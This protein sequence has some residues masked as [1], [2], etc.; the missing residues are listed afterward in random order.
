MEVSSLLLTLIIVSYDLKSIGLTDVP[1]ICTSKVDTGVIHQARK[2]KDLC[3]EYLNAEIQMGHHSSII[4][5]RATL[6][7]FLA[8]KDRFSLDL[9]GPGFLGADEINSSTNFSGRRRHRNKMAKQ[10]AY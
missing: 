1:Y 4:D 3:A 5:A 9:Y 7:L 10:G 8:T 6:A 2:L